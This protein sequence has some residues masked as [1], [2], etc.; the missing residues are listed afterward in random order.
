MELTSLGAAGEDPLIV[1]ATVME[2][3]RTQALLARIAGLCSDPKY[4]DLEIRCEGKSFKVHRNIVCLLSDVL[5]KECDG[6][7][8]VRNV[9]LP[10]IYTVHAHK[11]MQEAETNVI[12]HHVFDAITLSRMLEFMY[13]GLYKVCNTDV[14]VTTMGI[15]CDSRFEGLS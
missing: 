2:E 9:L 3:A 7:F 8:Q 12:E 11:W 10:H 5:A 6:G 13:T 14:E 1:S 4:C 15:A